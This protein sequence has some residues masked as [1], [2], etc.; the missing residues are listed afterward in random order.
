MLFSPS[1][2][3]VLSFPFVCISD[4][5]NEALYHKIDFEDIVCFRMNN[6]NSQVGCQTNRDGDGGVLYLFN[7]K[8]TLS[9]SIND[10]E[11]P[12]IAVI[13]SSLFNNETLQLLTSSQFT[14]G[15][16]MFEDNSTDWYSPEKS[17]PGNGFN[18][19]ESVADIAAPEMCLSDVK[20][21]PY[22][23]W[24]SY[25]NIPFGVFIIRKESEIQK[26]HDKA[27]ENFDLS[28]KKLKDYPLWGGQMKAFMNAAVDTA[29]CIRRGTCDAI[30]GLN[31]FSNLV[32]KTN[33]DKDVILLIVKA[34]ATAFFKDLSFGAEA[35]AVGLV[36][37]LGIV[38]SFSKIRDLD[39]KAFE[40]MNTEI[41][42]AFLQSESFDY[43]GSQRLAYDLK[44]K[45]FGIAKY[46][47]SLSNVKLIL[48]I[49]P[50]GMSNNFHLH[51]R[52]KYPIEQTLTQSFVNSTKVDP[53]YKFFRSHYLPPASYHSFLRELDS[54]P[55]IIITD[56]DEET[57]SRNYGSRYD[58]LDPDNDLI[59][60]TKTLA[61]KVVK[62]L[63]TYISK[64]STVNPDIEPEIISEILTCYLVTQNCSLLREATNQTSLNSERLSRY[65]SIGAHTS[66]ATLYLKHLIDHLSRRDLSLAISDCNS[67][68]APGWDTMFRD[69]TCYGTITNGSSAVS[70]AF[71]VKNYSSTEYSTWTESRW[72][73][74]FHVM[75][76]KIASHKED[77][78]I[79]ICGVVYFLLISCGIIQCYRRKDLVFNE[80]IS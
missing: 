80:S 72:S 62:V 35:S 76:F 31:L 24:L 59:L 36:T 14:R 79:F 67:T 34:D 21:N 9:E 19:G 75:I 60:R 26:I 39:V 57:L 61:E 51:T 33:P 47:M 5:V 50:V 70:P 28:A 68:N 73:P 32:P 48:E 40:K 52:N 45:Q 13:N 53:K 23:N 20:Y 22:G 49:G 71:V 16:L 56:T 41:I 77:V 2:I 43:S 55:G 54:T 58:I 46:N 78:S 1:C 7:D 65:S 38:N 44:T 64:D 25:K 69:G 30:G 63:Y 74:S 6:Y 3:L 11:I 42:F 18:Y 15:V 27:K 37:M 66:N 8:V 29:T 17:C 12:F 4:S 10:I